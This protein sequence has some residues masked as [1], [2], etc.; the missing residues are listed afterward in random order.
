MNLYLEI[1]ERELFAIYR[2]IS[3]AIW[4]NTVSFGFDVDLL[5]RVSDFRGE[6]TNGSLTDGSQ[7]GSP[8]SAPDIDLNN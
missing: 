6:I 8:L 4:F 3:R 5:Q 7:N 2:K 1:L